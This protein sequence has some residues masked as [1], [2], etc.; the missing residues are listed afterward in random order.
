MKTKLI[1]NQLTFGMEKRI[2]G[3]LE[4][5]MMYRCMSNDM[6]YVGYFGASKLFL[7]EAKYE[8]KHYQKLVDICLQLGVLPVVKIDYFENEP[9][10]TLEEAFR[11]AYT[12]EYKLYVDY[13]KFY[14]EC[15]DEPVLAQAILEF[16]EIQ[17]KSV[18]EYADHLSRIELCNNDPAALLQFDKEL[19]NL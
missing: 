3:E 14:A 19:L 1:N 18:G 10:T 5:Q 4:A 13:G 2:T 6:S 17:R 15:K 11:K 8:G 16:L 12:A 7:G 9:V